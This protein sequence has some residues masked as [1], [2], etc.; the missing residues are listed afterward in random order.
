[1]KE[2]DTR[3][4]P[5]SDFATR[6]K[7]QCE[8]S[9]RKYILRFLCNYVFYQIAYVP[10]HFLLC[11]VVLCCVALRCVA[12]RCV[13]LCCVVLCCSCVVV[14]VVITHIPLTFTGVGYYWCVCIPGFE[15]Y[16][17]PRYYNWFVS[18]YWALT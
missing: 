18:E 14:V 15:W 7:R 4:R 2:K 13:V 10:Y 12:L 3:L 5:S 17:G 9:K 8:K 11:C 1:M 16:K 6:L